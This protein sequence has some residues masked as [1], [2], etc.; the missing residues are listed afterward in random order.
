M[1]D[2][3][4]PWM[5]LLVPLLGG[6]AAGALLNRAFGAW[7]AK[8]NA[9]KLLITFRGVRYTVPESAGGLKVLRLSYGG[10]DVVHILSR[11]DIIVRN[12]GKRDVLSSSV[13]LELSDELQ[14]LD[15]SPV[16]HAPEMV[17]GNLKVEN[18]GNRSVVEVANLQ[19]GDEASVSVMLTGSG[20]VSW[21][22]R[23][24]DSVSV[25]LERP[26]PDADSMSLSTRRAMTAMAVIFFTITQVASFCLL[27]DVDTDSVVNVLLLS[28]LVP[29]LVMLWLSW[30][31][32]VRR[33]VLRRGVGRI[34]ERGWESE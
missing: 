5:Q 27:I 32:S 33:L 10:T 23:G 26:G 20:K 15:S 19:P 2:G 12:V 29:F 6:G 17:L 13:L 8:R 3:F 30:Q 16:V 31:R 1:P 9:Q 21:H 24:S 18:N 28:T 22:F 4:S 34:T 11:L 7:E 14:L 25:V